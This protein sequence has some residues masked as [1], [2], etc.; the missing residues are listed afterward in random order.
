M[1]GKKAKTKAGV[2][3]ASFVRRATQQADGEDP[4]PSQAPLGGVKVGMRAL[5][6]RVSHSWDEALAARGP[7]QL[8]LMINLHSS[9]SQA[10]L[11][12]LCSLGPRLP[13]CQPHIG[14]PPN[15]TSN[16][17]ASKRS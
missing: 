5:H 10:L 2:L 17:G 11:Y 12:A 15:N 9:C 7:Q 6:A 4:A 8:G 14:A 13:H 16:R 3:R 1:A